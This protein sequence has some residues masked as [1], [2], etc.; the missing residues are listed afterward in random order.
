MRTLCVFAGCGL[1]KDQYNM[2]DAHIPD[3]TRSMIIDE[4]KRKIDEIH[5]DH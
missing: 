1:V 4:F 2:D 5:T 3:P